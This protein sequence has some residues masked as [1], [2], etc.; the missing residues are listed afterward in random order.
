MV[1]KKK[2]HLVCVVM[3]K[4]LKMVAPVRVNL[5][6]ISLM[7]INKK[8]KLHNLKIMIPE[9]QLNPRKRKLFKS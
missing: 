5:K 8:R 2:R 1:T 9:L 4:K 6:V 3:K 7:M